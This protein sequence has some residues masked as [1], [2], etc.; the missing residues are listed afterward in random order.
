VLDV[1]NPPHVIVP[2]SEFTFVFSTTARATTGLAAL[3]T[4]D[5]GAG[6]LVNDTSGFG[7]P[8]TLT[9][10]P[11]ENVLWTTGGLLFVAGPGT[12]A[13]SP[14]AASKIITAC[15]A[16]NE[17][18]LEAWIRPANA[19][20][21]GPARVLTLSTSDTSRNFMLGQEGT[22]YEARLR[23]T[24]TNFNGTPGVFSPGQAVLLQT[25][26][27]VYTRATGGAARLYLNGA[28][29]SDEVRGGSLSNWSSSTRFALGNEFNRERLWLG[30]YRLI[31]VYSRALSAM[32]VT[33]NY[34]AGPDPLPSLLAGDLNCDGEIGFKDINPF[35]LALT[36]PAAYAAQYPDCDVQVADIN[37]NGSVGFDDINPFVAL[38][39]AN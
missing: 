37:G 20:Q 21:G 11:L 25:H 35:V 29:V 33:D 18:T 2:G 36:N 6:D 17:V 7:T 34:L 10:A 26:H 4:F 15:K 38:L 39:T 13:T 1:E 14:A 28:L 5:E 31:A 23:T 24:E 3:Y 12:A 32:E 19:I 16:S 27:V 8:L 30:E 22:A 9:I